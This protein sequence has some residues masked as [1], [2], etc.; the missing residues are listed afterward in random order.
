MSL[1]N[2]N[3]FNIFKQQDLLQSLQQLQKGTVISYRRFMQNKMNICQ[4]KMVKRNLSTL[5][6]ND[7]YMKYSMEL[8]FNL[9]VISVEPLTAM[10]LVWAKGKQE[11]MMALMLLW[12]PLLTA[13]LLTYRLNNVMVSKLVSFNKA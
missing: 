4:L 13:P 8:C 7:S 6:W 11:W 1:N 9:G 2:K 5:L 12:L 10:R 3:R